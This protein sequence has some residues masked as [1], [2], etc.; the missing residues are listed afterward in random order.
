MG[1]YEKTVRERDNFIRA[2]IN[3]NDDFMKEFWLHL[4][5]TSNMKLI[6]LSEKSVCEVENE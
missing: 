1:I 5:E 6:E 2:A 3:A 4:A